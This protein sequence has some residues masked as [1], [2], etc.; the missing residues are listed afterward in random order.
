ML[1]IFLFSCHEAKRDFFQNLKAE[2]IFLDTFSLS[3]L[4]GVGLSAKPTVRQGKNYYAF[5]V[6]ENSVYANGSFCRVKDKLFFLPNEADTEMLFLDLR[7]NTSS[8]IAPQSLTTKNR[9]F[10]SVEWLGLSYNAVLRDSVYNVKINSSNIFSRPEDLLFEVS[11]NFELITIEQINC[12]H[13][14]LTINFS[15][16]EEVYFKHINKS[17]VCL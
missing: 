11:K 14:T 17:A 12:K 4:K 7:W 1:F 10:Y 8:S 6:P 3:N 2:N 15:P 13:D 9:S 16:K 5:N